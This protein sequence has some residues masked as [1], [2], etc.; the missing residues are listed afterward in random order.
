M[1]KKRANGV[2]LTKGDPFAY[3]T[4][5]RWLAEAIGDRMDISVCE[6]Y[7]GTNSLLRSLW[8][9]HAALF[10][11]VHVS[12]ASYDIDPPAEATNLFPQSPILRA[13]T[14]EHVPG[15]YDIIITN[16]PYLA[17][18]SAR[19]RGLPFPFDYAGTGIAAPADLYQIALDSCL[20]ACRH[21]AM[22]IPESFITS[23]YD[24][25][26][27]ASAISLPGNLFDDTEC[28][29]CLA[30]F[31]ESTSEGFDIVSSDGAS[32][33]SY[34]EASAAY[35]ACIGYAMEAYPHGTNIS[36]NVPDGEI[37]LLGV[38]SSKGR[39]VCFVDGAEIDPARI[40]GTSR[41][42]TRMHAVDM[43]GKGTDEVIARA[44]EILAEWRSKTCDVFMTAF[45]GTIEGTGR[46]RRRLS[47][48][49]AEA[50]LNTAIC[51]S[52]HA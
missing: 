4:V 45:K 48:R 29:V 30:L 15:R 28:P 11:G 46:Y 49:E 36:F 9:R 33:I 35:D 38:D 26:R 50:I 34:A 14:L 39:P 8:N 18:N 16:P 19:R 37:G 12:W 21:A 2:Y 3:D 5:S 6:P 32:S 17:R 20:A 10:D 22:L 51:Q 44:N 47:F 24:K 52:P 40:K 1:D 27:L 42:I 43:N 23:S 13:D 25:S 31:A 41:S 7:A